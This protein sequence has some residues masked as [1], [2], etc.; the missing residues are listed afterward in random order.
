M[1]EDL[2][3]WRCGDVTMELGLSRTGAGRK[4]LLL[5]AP[6]SIS[7]RR[8]MAPLQTL[9][10]DRYQSVSIDWPGF[11]DRAKPFV[12]W[13][14][15]IYAQFLAAVLRDVAPDAETIVAAGHAAGYVLRH[16]ARRGLD[17]SRL[18]LV[19]PTWR[20]PFPTMMSGERAWFSRVRKAIDVPVAGPLLYGLNVNTLVLRHMAA[21]HVYE[22]KGFLA[23]D[24]LHE[25]RA[26]TTA[27]GAR[28]ASA[29][30]VTGGLDPF[31]SRKDF[32]AAAGRA[33]VPVRVVYGAHT[34]RRSRAEMEAMRD[35]TNVEMVELPRG[36][37]SV[38]E[39]FPALVAQAIP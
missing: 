15:E 36:K 39:E 29:R 12:D 26:V 38:H 35:V 11:G 34:P 10:A 25:K 24:R 14:P 20:G 21:G 33:G 7:T 37:L 19:A 18:V 13:T 6:S 30:F 8:E 27:S 1:I 16:A 32:L 2:Y 9:L 28:H 22:D 3:H 5:P 23:G 31:E 17:A 4:A